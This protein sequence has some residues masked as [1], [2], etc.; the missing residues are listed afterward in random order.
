M[1]EEHWHTVQW[2]QVDNYGIAF[3]DESLREA[4]AGEQL[5]QQ[6]KPRKQQ[7]KMFSMWPWAL[8]MSN[9]NVIDWPSPVG[10]EIC[11]HDLTSCHHMRGT[12]HS[13]ER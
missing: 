11:V 6:S 5:R 2:K 8:N 3:V 1:L 12:N 13:R 4:T 9:G 7:F 10:E